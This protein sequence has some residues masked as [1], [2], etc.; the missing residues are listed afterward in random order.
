MAVV[1]FL[2][3]AVSRGGRSRSSK[4]S[5]PRD[6]VPGPGGSPLLRTAHRAPLTPMFGAGPEPEPGSWGAVR[7]QRRPEIL[8]LEEFRRMLAVA[9]HADSGMGSCSGCCSRPRFRCPNSHAST[10]PTSSSRAHPWDPSRYSGQG[11]AGAVYAGPRAVAAGA[12][13]GCVTRLGKTFPG[14]SALAASGAARKANV[15]MTIMIGRGIL[16]PGRSRSDSSA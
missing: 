14:S 5:R 2:F 15:T 13:R 3:A 9:Y 4:G 7:G 1:A 16:K 11:P 12:P 6:S 8:T 10:S